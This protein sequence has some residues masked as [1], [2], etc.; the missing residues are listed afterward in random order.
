[1]SERNN[2]IS[3]A[4]IFLYVLLCLLAIYPF[5]MQVNYSSVDFTRISQIQWFIPLSLVYLIAIQVT[6]VICRFISHYRML[7]LLPFVVTYVLVSGFI[8][9]QLPFV[10]QGDN[11]LHSAAAKLIDIYGT[12]PPFSNAYSNLYPQFFILS[13][14]FSKILGMEILFSN[15]FLVALIHIIITMSMYLFIDG[16]LNGEDKVLALIIS[17]FSYLGNFELT[18][19]QSFFTPRLFAMPLFYIFLYTVFKED[20]KATAVIKMLLLMAMIAGH[21]TIPLFLLSFVVGLH[22]AYVLQNKHK[23]KLGLSIL[24]LIL[25]VAWLLYI[26]NYYFEWGVKLVFGYAQSPW[27]VAYGISSSYIQEQLDFSKDF[28]TIFLRAYRFV[29][30]VFTYVIGGIAAGFYILY[31]ILFMKKAEISRNFL[32]SFASF[33]MFMG[34]LLFYVV[35]GR[36]HDYF[37]LLSYTIFTYFAFLELTSMVRIF[38]KFEKN[39]L[40][41]IFSLIL[42]FMFPLSFFSIHSTIIYIGPSDYNGL[43][44]LANFGLSQNISTTG[45]IFY[46]YAIF[47]PSYFWPGKS[48]TSLLIYYTPQDLIQKS[49]RIPYVF[50]GDSV[51]R[52]SKQVFDFYFWGLSPDFWEKIDNNLAINR[53]KIYDNNYMLIWSK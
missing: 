32:L 27:F 50:E 48:G 26:S 51:I 47:N 12:L 36:G 19:Y 7:R 17:T 53:N 42:I 31:P 25:W 20:S 8:V 29:V 15:T 13:S 37:Y 9:T 43:T 35:T 5:F 6:L 2:N 3:T 16:M 39:Q 10:I 28:I 46:D 22:S 30:I 4:Q 23:A 34:S 1:M 18:Y 24:I 44:F 45:D 49:Q 21:P 33:S 41:F 40:Y 11:I 14:I 38:S 52:S